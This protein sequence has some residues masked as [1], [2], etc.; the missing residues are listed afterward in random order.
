MVLRLDHAERGSEEM[1]KFV[2]ALLLFALPI[3]AQTVNQG[4]SVT[5]GTPV[6]VIW[7]NP[8]IQGDTII[9]GV[10]PPGG[11]FTDKAN[12][13]FVQLCSAGNQAIWVAS[14]VSVFTG[15]VLT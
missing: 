3:A 7:T 10:V 4:A 9:V 8:Q 14:P 15:N 2:L 12:D 11:T 1:K 5:Q 13:S 6:N